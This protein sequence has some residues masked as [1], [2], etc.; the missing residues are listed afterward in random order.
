MAVYANKI[1]ISPGYGDTDIKMLIA[2][3]PFDYGDY[4]TRSSSD[5]IGEVPSDK[6]GTP[7]AVIGGGVAGLVAAFELMRIGLK[8][9]VYEVSDVTLGGRFSSR[10]FPVGE[11][12]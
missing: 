11:S 5:G 10:I 3:F 4:L 9:V 6:L 2:D 1:A 7:V 8:P 12:Q